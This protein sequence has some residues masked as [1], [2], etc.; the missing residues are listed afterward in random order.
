MALVDD[1]V[2]NTVTI[3]HAYFPF[4]LVKINTSVQKSTRKRKQQ[5]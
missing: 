1:T 5:I 4:L 2:L 3:F